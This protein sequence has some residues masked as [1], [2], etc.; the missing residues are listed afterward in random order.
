M[1]TTHGHHIPG[2]SFEAEPNERARCN[3]FKG[4]SKCKGEL[5]EML[6]ELRKALDPAN[7]TGEGS[8]FEPKR[9]A[10]KPFYVNALQTTAA[11]MEYISK[12]C[13]GK[14]EQYEH[15]H[16]N[17][18]YVRVPVLNAPTER[19]SRAH[20]GDWVVLANGQFKVYTAQAF[21]RTFVTLKQHEREIE[22]SSVKIHQ[23]D[24][25]EY[26]TYPGYEPVRMD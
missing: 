21:P 19:M 8:D 7:E 4:C 11:N 26:G 13:H 3:G 10:R 18:P 1:Y 23:G 20:V 16:G 14:I 17:V 15:R 24:A 5:E 9:F 25:R 6:S 12:W 2:T 22:G